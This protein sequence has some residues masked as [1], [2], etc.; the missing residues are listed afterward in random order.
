VLITDVT[1][2]PK[3]AADCGYPADPYRV[4]ALAHRAPASNTP[5]PTTSHG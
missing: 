1:D 5:G 4:Q 2:L 3:T